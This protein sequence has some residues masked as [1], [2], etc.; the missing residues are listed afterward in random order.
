MSN[1]DKKN[2]NWWIWVLVILGAI[3]LFSFIQE[4]QRDKELEDTVKNATQDV[5]YCRSKAAEYGMQGD[6]MFH[7]VY[8]D[9]MEMKGW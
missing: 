2:S 5:N 7:Q 3:F 8:N 6:A 4:K 9:C 1:N